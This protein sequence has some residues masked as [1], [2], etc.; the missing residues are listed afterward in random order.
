MKIAIIEKKEETPSIT[1]FILKKKDRY[2]FMFTASSFNDACRLYS[3]FKSDFC[4]IHSDEPDLLCFASY[5]RSKY[6]D[7]EVVIF[8]NKAELLSRKNSKLCL[9]PLTEIHKIDFCLKEKEAKMEQENIKLKVE[10]QMKELNSI[11]EKYIRYGMISSIIMGK[12]DYK[13]VEN[14]F[15]QLLSQPEVIAILYLINVK[16]LSYSN[17]SSTSFCEDIENKMKN[18]SVRV[19]QNYLICLYLGPNVNVKSQVSS[20]KLIVKDTYPGKLDSKDL[21]VYGTEGSKTFNELL[22][23]FDSI[24]KNISIRNLLPSWKPL[25]IYNLEIKLSQE[26]ENCDWQKV[27]GTLKN[28]GIFVKEMTD[29]EVV[30]KRAY[31]SHLWRQI[32]RTIWLNTGKLISILGKSLIDYKFS[33][34]E[35]ISDFNEITLEFLQ[36]L[37]SAM[38]LKNP[39]ISNKLVQ[40]AKEY[41]SVNY[42]KKVS[43][44]HVSSY[45]GISSCHLS[46]IFKQS[47]GINYKSYITR[48]R[49]ER[50]KVLLTEGNLNVS[51]VSRFVGYLNPN[52]FSQ[53][54]KQY[55]GVAPTDFSERRKN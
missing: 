44:E 11:T 3:Q 2:E 10:S 25:E 1:D 31:Y 54:F 27:R 42:M 39:G 46:K 29:D 8:T 37:V 38:E 28:L 36:E 30:R 22:S 5:L 45:L 16:N 35:Q 21:D 13:W 52:Y 47:V 6:P 34:V 9:G 15:N 41:I 20:L 18:F 48:I 7:V 43:L 4:I 19:F 33:Q 51:E 17:K 40:K 49:M 24:S 32:D 23:S 55:C 26:V 53:A 12:V 14:Y 50:A